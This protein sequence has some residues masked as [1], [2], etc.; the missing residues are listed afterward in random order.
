MIGM[1]L[2]ESDNL[3]HFIPFKV[4]VEELWGQKTKSKFFGKNTIT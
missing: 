2:A 1:P 4:S 3:H